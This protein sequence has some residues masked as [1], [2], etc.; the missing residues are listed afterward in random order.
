M[1]AI[2]KSLANRLIL[3]V[4]ADTFL[5]GYIGDSL[6]QAGAQIL[7]PARTVEEANTSIVHLR[8][9]PHAAVVSA[10]IFEAAGSA[11]GDALTVLGVPLLLIAGRRPLKPETMSHTM[12]ATPFAAYQIV[13]YLTGVLPVQ[14]NHGPS[15][16][17]FGD[18][19]RGH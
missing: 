7:G 19:L 6:K 16:R 5:A 3:L 10:D 13:D 18:T 9:P 4:E 11:I 14:K 15:R 17:V 1:T 2:E 8:E 12:L